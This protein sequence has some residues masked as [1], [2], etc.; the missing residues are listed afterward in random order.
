[1]LMLR[2]ITSQLQV[3]RRVNLLVKFAFQN[4]VPRS[5]NVVDRIRV[6]YG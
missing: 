6:A 5:M 1:M 2:W 4:L 3:V